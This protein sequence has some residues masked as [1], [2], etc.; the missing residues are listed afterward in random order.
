MCF[1]YFSAANKKKSSAKC[2]RGMLHRNWFTEQ[3]VMS[4]DWPWEDRQPLPR[5]KVTWS[6]PNFEDTLQSN[7]QSLCRV[8]NKLNLI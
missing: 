3:E 6:L 4:G 8:H 1:V 5:D 7:A 2:N